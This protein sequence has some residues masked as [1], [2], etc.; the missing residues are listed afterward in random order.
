MPLS[1]VKAFLQTNHDYVRSIAPRGGPE[2]TGTYLDHIAW[3]YDQVS[4]AL[5]CALCLCA[6]A[7][8][9][10]CACVHVCVCVCVRVCVRR[11]TACSLG[12]SQQRRPWSSWR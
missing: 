3:L 12:I 10:V 6:C 4:A 5:L 9:S 1:Q 8:V 2:G 7:C 11:W